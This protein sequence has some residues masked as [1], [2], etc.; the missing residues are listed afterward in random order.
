MSHV[1]VALLWQFKGEGGDRM[2][3][4]PLASRSGSGIETSFWLERVAAIHELE[5][6]ENCPA[7]CY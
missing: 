2:H 3:G 5:E 1:V 4:F 7:L 6:L